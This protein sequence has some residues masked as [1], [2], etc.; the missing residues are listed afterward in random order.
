M[1]VN[2]L[3]LSYHSMGAVISSFSPLAS[4]LC[5]GVTGGGLGEGGL[6]DGGDG[7]VEWVIV[8]WVSG[9]LGE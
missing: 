4:A 7:C 9:V 1:C 5:S 2:R 3:L 8:G 6:S